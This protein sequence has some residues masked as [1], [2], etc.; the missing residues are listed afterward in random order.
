MKT[1]YEEIAEKEVTKNY[2]EI[3]KARDLLEALL[4]DEDAGLT[5]YAGEIIRQAADY[6]Q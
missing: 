6:I 4:E 5:S 2:N 1:V 3:D